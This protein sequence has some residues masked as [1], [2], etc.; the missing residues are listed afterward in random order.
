[1]AITISNAFI[2]EYSDLVRQLAQQ[3]TSRLRG[4]VY[5]VSSGGEAYNFETLGATEAVEKSGRRVVTPYTDDIWARRIADPKTFNHVYTI[6]HEDRVQMLVDPQ[7]NYARGQA[8]AMNR[9]MD[10]QI[11]S[12]AFGAARDQDGAGTTLAAEGQVLGDG[13]AAISFDL[14]TQVQEKFM[15]NEIMPDEQ[16]CMVVSPAQVRKLMQLTEQTSSDYVRERALQELSSTGI[17]IG[18]MGFDWIVSNRLG[19][20]VD[21]TDTKCF[22]FTRRGLGL[23]VNQDTFTRIGEDP[24]HSYMIQVFSQWTL[25]AVR[26]EDEH[27]VGLHVLD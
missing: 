16:K 14:I 10:D 22:A 8:Y 26:V 12:A 13:S 25:G 4:K 23:A 18:W 19:F 3:E 15:E 27:V 20:D 5:E 21:G 1:M 7:S 17:T 6:E 24:A 11:I 2:N 9:A